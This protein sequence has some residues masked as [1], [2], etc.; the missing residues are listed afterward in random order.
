MAQK[1]LTTTRIA[2]K[3]LRGKSG[4][5]IALMI[6]VAI[7][8]F[9]LFGGSILTQGLNSGMSSL[10]ARLGADIAV[11]PPGT[12]ADYESQLLVG[13]PL[14]IYFDKDILQQVSTIAGVEQV[15]PQFYLA[16]YPDAVC[17]TT[18]VQIVG[19][20]YATD[21]VVQPWISQ[22]IPHQIGVEEV[23][24]GYRVGCRR[25]VL[26]FFGSTFHIATRLERTGTGMDTTVFMHMDTAREI[27]IITQVSGYMSYNIDI[28]NAIS[29]ILLGVSPG[30]DVQEVVYRIQR[31]IPN[32]GIVTSDGIYS[33]VSTSLR[34][35]TGVI[36][37][38]MIAFGVLAVLILAALFSLIAN[39]RKKEF[40]VL[41]TIGAT[42]KK[43]GGI[44]LTEALIIS[45]CGAVLG[46]G[47]AAMTV[48]PLGRIISIQMGMPLLLPN[49]M[50]TLLLL[51]FSLTISIA[52]GPLSATYSA[53]KISRAETYATMREGE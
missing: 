49:S 2:R 13:A 7:M 4:S 28:E 17:C 43:L 44:V 18:L 35:F 52:V 29:T 21:F 50:D 11:V 51:A 19:I 42:R 23:V 31:N 47:L 10:E 12:E 5:T 14:S 36:R 34:F 6:I 20:D 38:I 3:N 48:F 45:L 9:A 26:D 33:N 8:A 27:A 24:V 41:R 46:S 30:Y 37:A 40:A 16:A 39:S 53:Y 25:G 15:T 32:V 22:F 1:P